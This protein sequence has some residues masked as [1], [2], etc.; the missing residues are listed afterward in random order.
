MKE[1]TRQSPLF[2]Y[3][4]VQEHIHKPHRKAAVIGISPECAGMLASSF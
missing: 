2:P 4:H 3:T 1:D